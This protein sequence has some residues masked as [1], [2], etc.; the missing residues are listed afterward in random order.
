MAQ[1]KTSNNGKIFIEQDDQVTKLEQ[2][3]LHTV[4][5]GSQ[6]QPLDLL[7]VR[8]I[9]LS[10]E[11]I[12][13]EE[14]EGTTEITLDEITVKK[15]TITQEAIIGNS[16][17]MTVNTTSTFN[18][19]TTYIGDVT[20][21]AAS[22]F[23]LGGPTSISGD[24]TLS[25][26]NTLSG[27]TTLSGPNTISGTATFNNAVVTTSTVNLQ[28]GVQVNN[29]ST[30]D[31]V[32]INSGNIDGT[33]IGASVPAAGTFTN[34]TATS[35]FIGNLSG[36]VSSTGVSTFNSISTGTL[37][38]TG[39][40]TV[41][42]ADVSISGGNLTVNPGTPSNPFYIIGNLVGN[43]QGSVVDSSGNTVIDDAG[44]LVGDITGNVT[45]NVTGNL[46]GNVSGSLLGNVTAT[47]G[48]STFYNIQVD[49]NAEVRNDLLV[50][51]K[52]NLKSDDDSSVVSSS[53][54]IG[55]NDVLGHGLGAEPSNLAVGTGALSGNTGN[56][57]SVAV[58]K[59][60]LVGSLTGGN[61][62]ALG[63]TAGSSLTTGSNV[64]TLGYNAQPTSSSA[65][66]E[67][68]L[69]D[70]NV[71]RFR[72]PGASFDVTSGAISATSITLLAPPP[73]G[74]MADAFISATGDIT[75]VVGDITTSSGDI[76]TSSGD[77]TTSSGTISDSK[78][79]LRRGDV[80]AHDLSTSSYTI[81]ATASSTTFRFY[82]T[83]GGNTINIDGSNLVQGDV[84]ILFNQTASAFTISI[85]NFSSWFRK[86]DDG[87]TNYNGSTVTLA[88]YGVATVNCI[89]NNAAFISGNV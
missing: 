5:I 46:I 57:N 78:G 87:G 31:Q 45:G 12:A 80:V 79:D 35:N 64:T 1:L 49:N 21:T 71:T 7:V 15:A 68:T 17:V 77:I 63:H 55:G 74:A 81:P 28:Q 82:G 85:S 60:A 2:D 30:L 23:T 9:I 27:T 16:G 86:V 58:G 8:N 53:Y 44:G 11:L 6:P 13:A 26:T 43:I 37:Q 40:V 4:Q 76:T 42:N 22:T 84:F 19:N 50:W 89:T 73:G 47:E 36:D 54:Q 18:G 72:V 48:I 3:L 39:D 51:G 38:T 59:N 52:I 62:T 33:E 67:V 65:T 41:S 83:A 56:T 10:G 61:N 20:S 25:G 34:A 29:L 88:E 66:N 69:G 14:E 24:A 32:D 70:A 75:T